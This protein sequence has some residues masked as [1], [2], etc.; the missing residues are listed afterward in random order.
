MALPVDVIPATNT[1]YHTTNIEDGIALADEA[2]CQAFEQKYPE[3]W[4]SIQQRRTFMC[5][6]LGIQLKHPGLSI[7]IL[8]LTTVGNAYNVT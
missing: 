7:S 1:A 3:A 4:E 5:D 6:I 8:A 2:L